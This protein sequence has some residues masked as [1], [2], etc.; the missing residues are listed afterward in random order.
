MGECIKCGMLRYLDAVKVDIV[1]HLIV[2]TGNISPSSTKQQYLAL[3][4][5]GA[6]PMDIS[7][8]ADA[9]KS[10]LSPS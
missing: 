8:T 6:T 10:L 7:Q 5:F 1:G 2:R 9:D 4:A 3:R